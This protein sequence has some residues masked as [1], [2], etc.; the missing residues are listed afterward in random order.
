MV[1]SI[2]DR[3]DAASV[4]WTEFSDGAPFDFTT[5]WL[6]GHAGTAKMAD[7]YQA[8]KDGSLPPVSFV[9]ARADVEDEHP[10][11]D[12]QAGEAWTRKVYEAVTASPVWSDT[13]L[14]FTYDEAG[15]FHDHVPP[16]TSC[17]PTAKDAASTEL[18]VR[19]PLLVISPY[20]R[21]HYVSHVQHEH[22]SITRFVEAVFDLPALTARDA[23]SDALLDMFDFS[24]TPTAALPDA[25]QAG[26]GECV[27]GGGAGGGGGASGSGGSGGGAG[28]GGGSKGAECATK[29]TKVECSACCDADFPFAPV[30][31]GLVLLSECGCN[32]GATCASACASSCPSGPAN[33]ACAAC[34]QSA[35]TKPDACATTAKNTCK[36]DSDCAPGLACNDTCAPLP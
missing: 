2:L 24:C 33:A 4:K 19:V 1:P 15:G 16:P 11:G 8:L 14:I 9:D 7:F 12:V 20:A 6:P 23:N 18:G 3:L 26:S 28:G 34:M 27:K 25:P 36:S 29:A 5:G 31:L 21:P 32:A 10:P 35:V 13:A 17:V 22:T 30:K